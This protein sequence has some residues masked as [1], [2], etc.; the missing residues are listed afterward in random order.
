MMNCFEELTL[1]FWMPAPCAR[2]GSSIAARKRPAARRGGNFFMKGSVSAAS[3]CHE[4]HLAGGVPASFDDLDR[5]QLIHEL[6]LPFQCVE[7]APKRKLPVNHDR[8]V[9]FQPPDISATAGGA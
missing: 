6:V 9:D 5:L 4:H 1:R 3:S 7:E 8:R 2:M